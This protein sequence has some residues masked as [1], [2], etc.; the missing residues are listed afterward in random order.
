MTYIIR[1]IFVLLFMAIVCS[2]TSSQSN[3]PIIFIPGIL[4]SRLCDANGTVVWGTATA[5]LYIE[6]LEL[7]QDSSAP[8]IR[9]CG[10]IERFQ[11]LGSFWANDQY[12]SLMNDLLRF[13]YSPQEGNIYIFDYDWRISNYDNAQLLDAFVSK[14][15]PAGK[16]FDIIA[17]SMGGIIS[18]IYMDEYPSS[19]SLERIIYLGTP[20]LGSMNTFGVIKEGWTWPIPKMPGGPDV[21][22]DV[23]WRVSLSFP[24][25]LELLPRYEQCCYI[26]KVDGSRQFLDVFDPN[27]WRQLGWL[28]Q[29]YLE[30]DKFARFGNALQRS[31]SLTNL[32][33]RSA[34]SGVWE[35]IF[36]GDTLETLRRVGMREGFTRPGDWFFSKARGD[37]TV[38][39]WSAARSQKSDTYS[40]T[41]PSFGTH[42]HLFADKW[43][44]NKMGRSLQNVN[45]SDPD[46]VN[47]PGRP[48]LAVMINGL[49]STWFIDTADV[50]VG[51][52]F[53]RPGAQVHADLTIQF[54]SSVR[55][56]ATNVYKPN[57][58]LLVSG[59]RLPLQVIYISQDLDLSL[60]RLHFVAIGDAPEDEGA[61]EIVFQIN[62]SFSPSKA[63]YL[64][65]MAD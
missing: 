65:Q 61:V 16:P 30:G 41:L 62:D 63:V 25:M 55:D 45:P 12:N 47:A 56:L 11:I 4:G 28:P 9:P 17:H 53:L 44:V 20:F 23:I 19:R 21:I 54:E 27:V 6:K 51:K 49:A 15:I 26:R 52:P 7:R 60:K 46:P 59:R 35:F 38:P 58:F 32:L 14:K 1:A 37:G 33:V 13:G 24:S 42:A 22:Q 64:T 29:S 40:N 39:V 57:A 36:A 50:E 5:F 34:P 18:R 3:R 10:L 43:V 8:D 48:A 31:R 2:P